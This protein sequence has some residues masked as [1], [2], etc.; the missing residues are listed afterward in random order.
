MLYYIIGT[1]KIYN[2]Y[3]INILFTIYLVSSGCVTGA[4]DRRERCPVVAR[5]PGGTHP[6][7]GRSVTRHRGPGRE[8]GAASGAY[9]GSAQGNA[10]RTCGGFCVCP[11]APR[12][13][14]GARHRQVR[15]V[16]LAARPDKEPGAAGRDDRAMDTVAIS[17]VSGDRCYTRRIPSRSH[18]CPSARPVDAASVATLSAVDATSV[19]IPAATAAAMNEYRG[20]TTAA[21]AGLYEGSGTAVISRGAGAIYGASAGQGCVRRA[22]PWRLSHHRNLPRTPCGLSRSPCASV[23]GARLGQNACFPFKCP[24]R[25][26]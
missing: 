19:T 16:V 8:P 2:T 6:G 3:I 7:D 18:G 1:V 9:A 24:R 15:A 23:V 21:A 25:P 5:H 12:F 11:E 26:C 10:R 13:H 14:G 4:G 17:G 22:R 20:C